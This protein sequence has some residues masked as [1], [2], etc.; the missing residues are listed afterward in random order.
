MRILILGASGGCGRWATNLAAAA[1][2]SITAVVREGTA[3]APPADVDVQRGSVLDGK[4]LATWLDGQ[5]A[6]IS[7]IG[8]QRVSPRNPWS[9]LRPP[10]HIVERTAE[11]L[12]ETA[13]SGLRVAAISAAGV[14]D[15]VKHTNGMMR[16]LLAHS[17][18]GD[19]YADLD[20]MERVLRA[21][22]LDWI[23]VRPVVL[24]DA[25]PSR[26]ARVLSA[27]RAHSVIGRA[28]VAAWLLAAA[29]D[30]SPIVERTPMI[31]WW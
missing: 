10:P 11:T 14:G 19:M 5:D 15:S 8:S 30:P 27:F 3:F 1:G 29:T 4:A 28:D 21:S 7:C 18:V 17:T 23:A 31:G 6:V 26:R 24:I 13:G 16:W 12:V 2:H 25:G 9:P 22:T 20:A